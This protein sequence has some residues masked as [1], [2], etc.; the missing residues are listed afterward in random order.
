MTMRRCLLLVVMAC[1]VSGAALAQKAPAWPT[2]PIKMLV[3][4]GAGGAADVT[5]RLFA[6]HLGQTFGQQF[7][8][9]N[10]TGGGGLIGAMA[11][12]RAEPDGY[13]LGSGG[14]SVHVLAAA[15]SDNPGFDPVKDFTHIAFFGG[16]PS[17]L[18]AHPSIGVKTL[19]DMLA[20]ARAQSKEMPYV[21]SGTGTVGHIVFEYVVVKEKLNGV[22]IPYRAGSAAVIDLLAGRVSVGALNW[23]TA[24][25]HVQAGTLIPLAVSSAKRL[26]Q[27]PDL[28][29]LSELGYPDIVTTT[30]TMIT[31]PAGLPPPVVEA[32]NNAVQRIAQKPELKQHFD[33][34]GE[35][36]RLMTAA[37]LTQFVAAEVKR[38]APVVRAM[39]KK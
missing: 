37:Q 6:E 20:Y 13:T 29:T 30:W 36:P 7:V 9:E 33:N 18:V 16:A 34:E 25:Q 11:L 2:K 21:S 28:P 12:A 8:V 1:G 24:R 5:A 14:M 19:K 27:L 39:V 31:G 32:V 3:P 22:H 38:W 17:V 23:A 35:A 26:P 4:Y 15:L 10:R